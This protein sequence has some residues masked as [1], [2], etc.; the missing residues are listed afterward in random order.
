MAVHTVT[1]NKEKSESNQW[2]Q[3]LIPYRIYEVT[4]ISQSCQSNGPTYLLV[5][6]TLKPQD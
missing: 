4:E 1:F 6:L 2:L 3:N 5:S